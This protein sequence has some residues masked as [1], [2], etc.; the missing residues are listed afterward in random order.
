[1]EDFMLGTFYLRTDLPSIPSSTC[2]CARVQ[3]AARR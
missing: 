1:L 3:Y 2:A